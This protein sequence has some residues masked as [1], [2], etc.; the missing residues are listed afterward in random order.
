MTATDTISL[1]LSKIRTNG[2]TQTR[3][4]M[5]AEAVAEYAEAM[6]EGAEFPA[7]V[8]FYDGADYYLAD[9]FHRHAAAAAAGLAAVACG[10][11]QGTQRDAVLFSVGA[12]ET[13]GLRRTSA[14]KRRAVLMMLSD[15]EWSAWS[16]REIAR[17]CLVGKS[18]V[19]RL[20]A[21]VSVPKGQIAR[22]EPP[23]SSGGPRMD[24]AQTTASG[25][26]DQIDPA[27]PPAA[28]PLPPSEPAPTRTVQRGGTTYQMAT[29]NIGRKPEPD[30]PRQRTLADHDVRIHPTP[31]E[32]VRTARLG[33]DHSQF[34]WQK[35]D[36]VR[37]TLAEIR[38]ALTH[39]YLNI[40]YAMARERDLRE[41]AEAYQ[42]IAKQAALGLEMVQRHINNKKTAE[43]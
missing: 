32:K 33:A 40:E 31:A 41:I 9:G 21:D 17:Q 37:R 13:H 35:V 6:R 36:R 8:V 20:R 30:Q 1:A 24:S 22:T 19:N 16:D 3:A 25:L 11:R 4:E 26:K 42:D 2:G 18:T 7:L 43:G 23:V 12:N 10:V 28:P 5:N 38:K 34:E 39:K 29:S 14:D 15:P 27:P